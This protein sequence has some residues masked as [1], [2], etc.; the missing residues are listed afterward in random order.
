M[1]K[2]DSI[3][4]KTYHFFREW[5]PDMI[6]RYYASE[7]EWQKHQYGYLTGKENDYYNG[8]NASNTD[9]DVFGCGKEIDGF[10]Y[11]YVAEPTSW[12]LN[13]IFDTNNWEKKI[14]LSTHVVQNWF[15]IK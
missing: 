10:D 11:E 2:K 3:L 1:D 7:R 14:N 5:E 13:A 6:S 12:F 15:N 8:G 9:E 4:T